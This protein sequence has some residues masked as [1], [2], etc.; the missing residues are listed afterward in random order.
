M[1][2]FM[3]SPDPIRSARFL[4]DRHVVKMVLETAQILSTVVRS[5]RPGDDLDLYK[6]THANHPCTVW[7]GESEPNFR[8]LWL[9]GLAL[10]GEYTRR[11][12]KTHKSEAIIRRAGALASFDGAGVGTTP[13]L[14]MPDEFRQRDV[15]AAYRDYLRAKYA[16]WAR[17]PKWT[18][19]SVLPQ[20]NPLA[21]VGPWADALEQA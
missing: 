10:A 8:W 5:Q 14:A 17:P 1:N 4:C 3:T 9:H 13:A 2:I 12:G 20:D 21:M 6:V 18:N 7:A 11:F 15:F 16:D 19:P